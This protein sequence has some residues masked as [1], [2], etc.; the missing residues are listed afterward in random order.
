MASPIRH[1]DVDLIALLRAEPH[2]FRFFQAIRLLALAEAPAGGP[3]PALPARIRFR[4]PATLAFPP[5]EIQGMGQAGTTQELAVGFFGLTGPSGVLPAH[6]TELLMD[7]KDSQRDSSAHAF[8]DLFTHRALALFY[9]AWRKYR[10][11]LAFEGGERH[12]FTAQLLALTGRR[13]Q[14]PRRE[15]E[16]PD[17]ILAHFSGTLARQPLPATTLLSLIAAYFEVGTALESFV[18]HWIQVPQAQQ[19][20]LGAQACTLSGMAFLGQRLWDRQTRIRLR[21]GPLSLSGFQ[22]LLPCTRAARSLASFVRACIGH[23][24]ACDLTLVLAAGA[25][26]APVLSSRLATPSRLGINL[27]LT[28]HPS[29]RDLDDS[30]FSLLA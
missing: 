21:V 12:G 27:W 16:A 29:E 15:A 7:R 13:P 30:I 20:R 26:K 8:L 9:A 11:P 19:S 18:G 25:A 17:L 6:Y 5:S 1:R 3:G 23:S 24:L 10:F 2:R 22:E 28:G 4:S 14:A